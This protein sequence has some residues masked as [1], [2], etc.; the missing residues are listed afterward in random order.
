MADCNPASIRR[1][2]LRALQ[3]IDNYISLVHSGSLKITILIPVYDDWPSLLE[4]VGDIHSARRAPFVRDPV[5][6]ALPR[7]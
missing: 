4:L 7:R 2:L 1:K 6:E 5:F 3:K